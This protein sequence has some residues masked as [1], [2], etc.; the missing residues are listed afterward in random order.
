MATNE[1]RKKPEA[2]AFTPVS[3]WYSSGAYASVPVL[4]LGGF[5][6]CS[7]IGRLGTAEMEAAELEDGLVHFGFYSVDFLCEDAYRQAPGEHYLAA[8][9]DGLHDPVTYSVPG[10]NIDPEGGFF[11]VREL[12][13]GDGEFDYFVACVREADNSRILSNVAD[14]I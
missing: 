14:Y 2:G 13:D 10:I 11:L 9:L 12:A 5:F 4:L 7:I 3:G 6:S 1:K 8:F